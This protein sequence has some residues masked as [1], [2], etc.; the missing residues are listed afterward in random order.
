MTPSLSASHG[1]RLL[2]F[3]CLLE[4]SAAA[5]GWTSESYHLQNKVLEARVTA[6][7]KRTGMEVTKPP[8][9]AILTFTTCPEAQPFKPIATAVFRS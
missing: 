7:F 8:G 9:A 1:K 5:G 4:Q 6:Q 2:H 3:S